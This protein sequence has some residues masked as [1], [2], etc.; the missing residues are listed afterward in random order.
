MAAATAM[1]ARES[2]GAKRVP[3]E[4]PEAPAKA[5]HARPQSTMGRVRTSRA[6]AMAPAARPSTSESPTPKQH[7]PRGD[8]R[9][10]QRGV[11][12]ALVIGVGNGARGERD[13]DA[14]R[15]NPP[16]PRSA[17]SSSRA[18]KMVR[19]RT[20]TKR[21]TA[22]SSRRSSTLSS[23]M[24]SRKTALATMVMTAMARWNRL[25]TLKVWEDSD[26]ISAEGYARN[27]KALRL[28]SAAAESGGDAGRQRRARSDPPG[29]ARPA[30]RRDRAGGSGP[31]GRA[32][33]SPRDRDGAR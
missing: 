29:R 22:A 19:R 31:A 2:A 12:E 3:A 25:T 24:Q 30:G 21:I 4:A 17:A 32:A 6:A 20:P 18:Q 23:M 7:D 10:D 5:G 9:E 28:S 27:P 33:R 11:E 15:P 8:D 26:A 1:P 16:R 14:Q 13:A